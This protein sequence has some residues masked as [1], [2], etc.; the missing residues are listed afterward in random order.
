M[1]DAIPCWCG[2]R[3]DLKCS[4]SEHVHSSFMA[5]LVPYRVIEFVATHLGLLYA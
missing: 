4:R 2:K 1:E 3:K 5:L